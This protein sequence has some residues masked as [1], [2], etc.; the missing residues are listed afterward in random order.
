MGNY[1]TYNDALELLS[2]IQKTGVLKDAFVVAYYNDER[3]FLPQ[4]ISEKI[5]D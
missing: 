4:L 2:R 1:A 5:L 3:K